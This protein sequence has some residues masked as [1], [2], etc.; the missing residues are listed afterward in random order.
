M[1]TKVLK[2]VLLTLLTI[3]MS[4]SFVFADVITPGEAAKKYW[5][6]YL[7]FGGALVLIMIVQY[8]DHKR[9]QK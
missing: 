4:V 7:I 1:N 2:T 6:Y 8:V 3:L 9:N 5:P